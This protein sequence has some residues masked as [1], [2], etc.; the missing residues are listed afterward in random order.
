MTGH[1]QLCFVWDLSVANALC[2]SSLVYLLRTLRI[3]LIT[4]SLLT[5]SA[6]QCQNN[7]FLPSVWTEYRK[8]K[9]TVCDFPNSL[10]LRDS[11]ALCEHLGAKWNTLYPLHSH[12]EPIQMRYLL[13]CYMVC[14]LST[15]K[16]APWVVLLIWKTHTYIYNYSCHIYIHTFG[17]C[18]AAGCQRYI[19]TLMYITCKCVWETETENV[20]ERQRQR[21]CVRDRDR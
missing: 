13:V 9:N 16:Q 12:P 2:P 10:Q 17:I 1:S 7:S 8:D 3:Q 18:W 15:Q 6:A 21:M 14:L 5:Y 20:C 19:L 4:N 11:D